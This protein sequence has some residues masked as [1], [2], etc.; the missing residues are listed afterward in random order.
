MYCLIFFLNTFK[1]CD[2]FMDWGREFQSFGAEQ[3][4][5]P[6]RSYNVVLDLG[7][8]NVQLA[9]DLGGRVWVCDVGFNKFDIYSGVRLF[10]ALY[11][12]IALL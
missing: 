12:R 1:D 6:L 7:I 8:D 3:E 10:N 4:K 5:E 2:I 9:V 11:V